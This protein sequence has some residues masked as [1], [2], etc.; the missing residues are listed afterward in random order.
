[1]TTH[2]ADFLVVKTLR[3]KGESFQSQFVTVVYVTVQ[4]G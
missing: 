3:G 2:T 4:S 1:M